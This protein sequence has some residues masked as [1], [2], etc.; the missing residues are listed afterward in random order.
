MLKELG[1]KITNNFGLKLLATLFAVVLWI[2]VVNIDDPVISDKFTTSVIAEN[3]DYLTNQD[4]YFEV[5]DGK[6]TV[7]F[8]ASAERSVLS[9]MSS[10]D[11]SATADMEKIE[12]DEKTGTYRVPVTIV[13]NRYSNKVTISSKQLYLEVTLEDLGTCQK[14]ISANTKGTVADGCAL[15]TLEIVGSNLLKVSGPSSI[16]SQIDSA[17]ATINVEGVAADVT[18]SVV[19]VL[20]DKDGNVIDMTKLKLSLSTVTVAAQILSTKDVTLEFDT[21]GKVESGYMITGIEYPLETVRIKGQSATLNPINKISI[22]AEVLD[23][24]DITDDLVTIVDISSYLPSG[25]SLVLTSDA[26]VEVTVKVE[27]ILS[28][29][30]EVPIANLSIENLRESYE[31]EFDE[32]VAVVEVSGPDSVVSELKAKDIKGTVDVT[33]LGVGNHRVAVNFSLEDYCWIT[34]TVRVPVVI[35]GDAAEDMGTGENSEVVTP[36]DS[37][38]DADVVQDG[39][40]DATDTTTT[41]NPSVSTPEGEGQDSSEGPAS[42]EE[43]VSSEKVNQ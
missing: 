39:S 4:K 27:P 24:T 33:S 14:V 26:K 38:G 5:L 21:T 36:E 40:T 18:D 32:D 41:M 10:S 7:T 37:A 42:S 19:P 20:Y 23:V 8:S 25:T 34:G 35:I 22:P 17:V 43:A 16:V 13:A 28:R 3:T 9:E 29:T 30:F 6:N 15:G 12:V 11:F 2:V 1:K 31:L